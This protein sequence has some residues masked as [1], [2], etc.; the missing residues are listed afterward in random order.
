MP[1]LTPVAIG[2]EPVQRTTAPHRRR[3]LH[4]AGSGRGRP[5]ASRHG[6][7]GAMRTICRSW[8]RQRAAAGC[9]LGANRDGRHD[10]FSHRVEHVDSSSLRRYGKS[11]AKP[12]VFGL[13]RL[14]CRGSAIPA[15]GA[16]GGRTPRRVPL[17]TGGLRVT[18]SP[19]VSAC[20][21]IQESKTCNSAGGCR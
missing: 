5:L 13:H 7:H 3:G 15:T 14:N 11:P 8:A 17:D 12:K 21:E 9:G 10:G 2:P 20:A 18:R 4:V 16:T 19:D 1:E 6:S